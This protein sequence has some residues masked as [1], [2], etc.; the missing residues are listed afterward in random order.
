M[1]NID[2]CITAESD[3]VSLLQE[4]RTSL[5]SEVVTGAIDVRS[6][7]TVGEGAVL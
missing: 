7:E 1:S 2:R 3:T 5:I 6:A 4:L